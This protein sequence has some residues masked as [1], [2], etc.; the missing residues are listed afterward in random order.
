MNTD[1][2]RITQHETGDADDTPLPTHPLLLQTR[3]QTFHLRK[4]ATKL[5]FAR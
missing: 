2:R 5:N 4:R 1:R 3:P